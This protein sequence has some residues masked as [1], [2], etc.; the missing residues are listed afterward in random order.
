MVPYGP[1]IE[2][3]GQD[4]FISEKPINIIKKGIAADVP[5]IISFTA[6][7]GLVGVTGIK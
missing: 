5:M 1:V 3:V 6:D 2:P 7:E 4:A